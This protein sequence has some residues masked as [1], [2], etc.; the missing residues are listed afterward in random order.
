[1]AQD[2]DLDRFVTAQEPVIDTV[3]A[4][5]D[6]GHKRTHWMWFVFPQ[7]RGLG[8]SDRAIYY[9]LEGAAEAAA[10]LAHPV[11]GPRLRD[12]VAR[13]NAAPAADAVALFGKIDAQK[14]RSC[15]TLFDAVAPDEACFASG[16]TRF[17]SGTRC[18][19]T[20]ERL[21]PT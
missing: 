13:A 20:V 9:G 4:E 2:F 8:Q 3:R 12:C 14:Y 17:Y 16:L 1:M 7:L 6:A 5:L 21:K 15:L 10:Y 18:E 19:R 11:L